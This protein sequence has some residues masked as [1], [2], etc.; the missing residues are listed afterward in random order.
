MGPG[1]RRDDTECEGALAWSR[2][3]P[4]ARRR[5]ISAALA[6]SRGPAM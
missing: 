2:R 5:R 1:L 3:L 6:V 4:S